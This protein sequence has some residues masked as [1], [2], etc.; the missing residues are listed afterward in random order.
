M[1]EGIDRVKE[2]KKKIPNRLQRG[3][4]LRVSQLWGID[5]PLSTV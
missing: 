4:E 2:G 5:S 1:K 3:K